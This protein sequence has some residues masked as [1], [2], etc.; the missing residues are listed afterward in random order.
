MVT[1]C[2]QN[3]IANSWFAGAGVE[4][5]SAVNDDRASACCAAKAVRRHGGQ[6][7]G[8]TQEAWRAQ[9]CGA[10]HCFAS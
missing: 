9:I 8:G 10:M 1:G 6:H 4:C 3:L 7:G 2:K 5:E